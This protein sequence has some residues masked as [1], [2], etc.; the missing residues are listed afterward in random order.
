MKYYKNKPKNSGIKNT[1]TE[2]IKSVEQFNSRQK[3]KTNQKIGPLKLQSL[4]R[5]ERINKG[6]QRLRD[7]WDTIRLTDT[8]Q[9]SHRK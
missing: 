9:G 3:E 2:L 7:L 4:R 1:I 5:K 6:G 8:N